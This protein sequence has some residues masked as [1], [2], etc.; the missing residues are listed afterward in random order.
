MKDYVI[1]LGEEVAKKF[2]ENGKDLGAVYGNHHGYR[3]IRAVY[4]SDS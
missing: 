4:G 3:V 1:F 2:P